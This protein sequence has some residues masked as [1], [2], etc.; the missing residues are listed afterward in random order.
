MLDITRA[1]DIIRSRVPTFAPL[2]ISAAVYLFF[3]LGLTK[4]QKII[5]RRLSAGDNR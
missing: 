2:L 5:E 4:I 3:V 1:G